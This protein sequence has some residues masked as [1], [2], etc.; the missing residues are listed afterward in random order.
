MA[1]LVFLDFDGVI[2]D[3]VAECL[4]S[5]WEAYYD[6][7]G[8]E[9]PN[10]VPADLLKRFLALRPYVRSG[11]DFV[12]CQEILDRGVEI[13]SQGDFDRYTLPRGAP[14]LAHLRE[15]FYAARAA[16]LQ[17]DRAYWIRLNRL[18]PWVGEYLPRWAVSPC[19][20]IL[21]TKRPE[22]IDEIL[23]AAGILFPRDRI[24]C[25]GKTEKGVRIEELLSSLGSESALIVDDQIDH[26]AAILGTS[27]RI[28]VSLAAWGYVKPEW[29]REASVPVVHMYEIG[30][31]VDKI[32]AQ[33][34]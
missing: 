15:Q 16:L 22:F 13:S 5:S 26:L 27:H 12:I 32:L 17:R 20:Y 23:S 3:S 14:A 28:E 24:L 1:P 33:C 30:A 19:V 11:E 18:Y 29:L 6:L 7:H 10:A 8:P 21:S 2:C 34:R 25:S 31:L 4:V 9:K